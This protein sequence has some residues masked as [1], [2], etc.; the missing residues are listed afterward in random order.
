MSNRRRLPARPHRW[1]R[2]FVVLVLLGPLG[3]VGPSAGAHA[4][5]LAQFPKDGEVVEEGSVPTTIQLDWNETVTVDPAGA[6]IRG[7]DAAV[8]S[9]PASVTVIPAAPTSQPAPTPS[10]GGAKSAPTRVSVTSTSALPVGRYALETSILS[11][12]GHQLV[13]SYGFAVGDSP[14]VT[15]NQI[16]VVLDPANGVG[17]P[18]N[19]NIDGALLGARTLRVV[20]PEGV[21]GGQVRLTCRRE[22]G[23]RVAKVRAPFVWKLNAPEGGTSSAAGYLPVACN[24]TMR[25]T[26]DREF[27]ASPLSY[28]TS[29]SRSLAVPPG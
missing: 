23:E 6:A 24:Y 7:A 11:P 5:L 20:V 21:K 17:A 1:W 22:A 3:L 16:P 18:L 14:Q 26:L 2:G 12:D 15:G 29:P 4:F 28:V 25:I 10:A 19:V 9:G 27:P 13:Q 8:L